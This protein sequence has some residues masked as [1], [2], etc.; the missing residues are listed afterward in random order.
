MKTIKAGTIKRIHVNRHI[1]AKNLKESK[2]DPALTIQTSKGPVPASLV[3]V[4]G[5][6]RFLQA[7][8]SAPKPLN[9]GARVWV[10]THGQVSYT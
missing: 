4:Q 3:E 2:N 6:V 9:C 7:G 10:E 8:V 5:V 1:L